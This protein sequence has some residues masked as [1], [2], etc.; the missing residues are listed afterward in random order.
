MSRKLNQS[1]KYA[2]QRK[3]CV[4]KDAAQYS[5][6]NDFVGFSTKLVEGGYYY[7]KTIRLGVL[8]WQ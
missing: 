8:W 7:C 5:G 4:E 1:N 3:I 2:F 6:E